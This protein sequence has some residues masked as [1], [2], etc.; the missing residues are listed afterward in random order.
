MGDTGSRQAEIAYEAIAP[1]YD[2]FTANHDYELWVGSL[3]PA[4]EKHG[5][6]GQRLLDVGCGT[7]KSAAP[8]L[9]R[10]WKI[11]AC[12]ISPSMVAI[13][14]QKLGPAVT[15]L[16]ADMCE[17]PQ[18]GEFDLVWAVDDAVNY[19]LSEGELQRALGGMASNLAPE[20]LLMFDLNTLE[21]FR[22]FFAETVVVDRGDRRLIWR[23]MNGSDAA[24]GTIGEAVFQ[25]EGDMDPPRKFHLGTIA[26]V[27]FANRRYGQLCPRQDWTVSPYTGTTTTRS[28]SS[29]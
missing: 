8:M 13:N 25:V 7:G 29:P 19:L 6:Q 2:E 18:L 26:S 23:G 10:G 11:S 4:L 21:S 3:L 16:V 27:T 12:D 14:R 1:V 28:S 17:L 24:P 5:L 9:E 15:F 22:T 20:G